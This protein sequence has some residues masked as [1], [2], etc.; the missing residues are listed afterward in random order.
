LRFAFLFLIIF[1]L[2][3][4]EVIGTDK[5]AYPE[6]SS[7][8]VIADLCDSE[9]VLNLL[10]GTN[11][12]FILFVFYVV[13]FKL[14]IFIFILLGVIHTAAIPGPTQTTPTGCPQEMA[15]HAQI[16]LEKLDPREVFDNNTKSSFN[17]FDVSLLP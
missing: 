13:Y 3:N 14:F 7:P 12:M 15:E 6:S 10:K 8:F 16:Q 9:Q 2:G 5:I 11:C 4:Y 1:F 17:I